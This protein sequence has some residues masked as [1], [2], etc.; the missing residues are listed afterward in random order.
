MSHWYKS[1]LDLSEH[2]LTRR[3]KMET[4]LKLKESDWKDKMSNKEG[5]DIHPLAALFK[6]H[7]RSKENKWM[8]SSDTRYSI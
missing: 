5:N 7:E 3:R 6:D 1:D 8:A 4:M 2:F